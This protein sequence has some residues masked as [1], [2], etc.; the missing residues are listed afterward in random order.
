MNIE[1]HLICWNEAQILP[2]VIKH[3][4]DFCSKIVIH[5]NYSNDGSDKI[6]RKLGC[7]VEYFGI[8]GKLDDLEYLK[9]KNN[10]WKGSAADY[11]IVADCD[12]ILH[13][14]QREFSGIDVTSAQLQF[15]KDNGTTIFKTTGWNIYSNKMPKD[16]LLEIT[17]GYLFE[18]YSKCIA[19]DPKAIIEMNYE[20]G[21]HRCTPVGNIQY[22][23]ELIYLLHYRCIGGVERLIDRYQSYRKRMSQNN[24]KKGYGIH[25]FDN[26]NR[27]RGEFEERLNKSKPLW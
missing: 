18:N 13:R 4:Q 27:L 17:T 8:T 23:Q 6:A 25:Y 19:F 12:E 10:C 14:S 2:L 5:D 20:P 15:E 9:V 26:E 3:Y 11:V 16:D 1:C 24:R 7:T 21:A 22:N